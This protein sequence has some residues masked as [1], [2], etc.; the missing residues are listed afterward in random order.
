[1]Q[2][3]CSLQASQYTGIMPDVQ[4]RPFSSYWLIFTPFFS[5]QPDKI[6][7]VADCWLH[8]TIETRLLKLNFCLETA[9]TNHVFPEKCASAMTKTDRVERFRP[10]EATERDETFLN[11]NMWARSRCARDSQEKNHL[12]IQTRHAKNEIFIMI[13][14]RTSVACTV[15]FN[16][17][18]C[19]ACPPAMLNV[20]IN[21]NLRACLWHWERERKLVDCLDVAVWLIV[22]RQLWFQSKKPFPWLETITR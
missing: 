21:K 13:H 19:W 9:K 10:R 8:F 20:P 11:A 5:P 4:W 6:W 2:F 3:K 7:F 18:A 22:L 12:L 14:G 17:N 15:Y 1:M 16:W